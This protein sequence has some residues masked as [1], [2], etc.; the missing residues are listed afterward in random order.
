ML[1]NAKSEDNVSDQES[2]SEL[3]TV[4]VRP[5]AR[6]IK[7]EKVASDEYQIWLTA[8]PEGNKANE[9]LLKILSEELNVPKTSL[10][11]VRG[12]TARTK[13]VLLDM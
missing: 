1:K 8:R 2:L 10:E 9:Q 7:V 6:R 11:I 13:L 4:R 12:H 3:F 5:G